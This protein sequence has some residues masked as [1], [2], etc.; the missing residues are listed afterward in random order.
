LVSPWLP[1]LLMPSSFLIQALPT[2]RKKKSVS[3]NTITNEIRIPMEEKKNYK[4]TKGS[5]LFSEMAQALFFPTMIL[6]LSSN[7]PFAPL[8]TW[9][10]TS[11]S[12]AIVGASS[13][14][15]TV[16]LVLLFQLLILLEVF[17]H[18]IFWVSCSELVPPLY[19]VG[20]PTCY[21]CSYQRITPFILSINTDGCLPGLAI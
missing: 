10:S 4:R 5:Y 16:H 3:I 13:C 1:S 2:S 14:W 15:K 18:V 12:L 7:F 21:S 11:T 8:E 17:G 20:D 19:C 6:L 9:F